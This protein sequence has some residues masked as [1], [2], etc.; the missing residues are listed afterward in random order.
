[1]TTPTA[2]DGWIYFLHGWRQV[3]AQVFDVEIT[4]ERFVQLAEAAAFLRG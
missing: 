1:M 3:V 2:E 4:D